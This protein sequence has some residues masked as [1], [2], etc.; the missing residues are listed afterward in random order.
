MT[1]YYWSPPSQQDLAKFGGAKTLDDYPE[2]EVDVWDENWDVLMMY[3]R[4]QTQW[5]A[6][7]RGLIGL[8]YSVFYADM[9][10]RAVPDETQIELMDDLRIIEAQAR[11]EL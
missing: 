4:N 11:K 7:P 2:P 10:R 3:I 5:R 6:S 1:G 9:S 8:D